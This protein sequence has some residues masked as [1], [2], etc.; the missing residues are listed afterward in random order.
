MPIDPAS[1]AFY[2]AQTESLRVRLEGFSPTTFVSEASLEMLDPLGASLGTI[3]GISIGSSYT[4]PD[5]KST[6]LN[7]SH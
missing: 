3:S 5:R 2:D 6:R 4:D 7:S 1:E